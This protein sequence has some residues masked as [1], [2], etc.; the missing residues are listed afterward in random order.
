MAPFEKISASLRLRETFVIFAERLAG[1]RSPATSEG[2]E[3]LERN[4]Q[5]AA[6]RRAAGALLFVGPRDFDSNGPG[7]P[8]LVSR[9][10][11]LLVLHAA[12]RRDAEEIAHED[13]FHVT[14]FRKNHLHA[15]SN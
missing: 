13:P 5:W 6:K 7:A 1:W 9:V 3:E 15:W 11:R 14:G 10:T 12:T 8:A 2:R 4:D